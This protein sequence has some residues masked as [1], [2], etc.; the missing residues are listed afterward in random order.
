MSP[1]ETVDATLVMAK[2]TVQPQVAHVAWKSGSLHQV[3][4]KGTI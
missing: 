2:K 3:L 4:E 1:I